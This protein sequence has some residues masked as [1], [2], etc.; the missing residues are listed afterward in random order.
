MPFHMYCA[1]IHVMGTTAVIAAAC[2]LE[3]V[4][5]VGLGLIFRPDNILML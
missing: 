3:L 1:A 5:A 4:V 2:I